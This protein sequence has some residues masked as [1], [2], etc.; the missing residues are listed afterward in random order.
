MILSGSSVIHKNNLL[1]YCHEKNV[2]EKHGKTK[3]SVEKNAPPPLHPSIYQMVAPLTHV[4]NNKIYRYDVLK[5]MNLS[6]NFENNI[7]I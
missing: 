3:L 7:N 2:C 6:S 4:T 1:P 5:H